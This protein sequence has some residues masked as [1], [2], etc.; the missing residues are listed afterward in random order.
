MKGPRHLLP[1]SLIAHEALVSKTNQGLV[2]ARG[3]EEP[4][5]KREGREVGRKGTAAGVGLMC[6]T[7]TVQI[8]IRASPPPGDPGH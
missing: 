1:D 2:R 7:L 5:E 4:P 3:G 8:I 6:L